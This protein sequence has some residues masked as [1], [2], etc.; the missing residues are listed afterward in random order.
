MQYLMQFGILVGSY[1]TPPWSINTLTRYFWNCIHLSG[2][3]LLK[4]GTVTLYM[5]DTTFPGTMQHLEVYT[6]CFPLVFNFGQSNRIG[7]SVINKRFKD[8]GS[9]NFMFEFIDFQFSIHTIQVILFDNI[10]LIFQHF[11]GVILLYPMMKRGNRY[12]MKISRL[13]FVFNCFL[14]QFILIQNFEL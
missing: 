13:A 6:R 7:G 9:G 14:I 8:I 5:G 11:M 2:F 12:K 10:S 1:G 4:Y 3:L